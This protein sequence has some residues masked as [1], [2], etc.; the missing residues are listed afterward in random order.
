LN[1]V[2]ERSKERA[3]RLSISIRLVGLYTLTSEAV[4]QYTTLLGWSNGFRENDAT[5][6]YL[7]S[8]SPVL[9]TILV[10]A[11]P[12]M[13][14]LIAYYSGLKWTSSSKRGKGLRL[15]IATIALL[16]TITLGITTT[17]ATISDY[18][19][20]HFYHLLLIHT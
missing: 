17:M 8:I 19:T 13:L 14:L 18:N 16:L 12:I 6:R 11:L 3:G 5:A 15:T 10:F 20:L 4:N 1:D 7:L 9:E 2:E